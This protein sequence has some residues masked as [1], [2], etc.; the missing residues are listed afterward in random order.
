MQSTHT[1]NFLQTAHRLQD[2][3]TLQATAYRPCACYQPYVICY[4]LYA[5]GYRLQ[6]VQVM[7][8]PNATD[9][10]DVVDLICNVDAIGPR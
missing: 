4:K 1:H 8:A 6:A 10:F 7:N 3:L 9:A 5:S 2:R